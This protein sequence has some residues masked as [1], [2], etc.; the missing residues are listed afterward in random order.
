MWHIWL[1]SGNHWIE[2]TQA[3]IEESDARNVAVQLKRL[4]AL[5]QVFM[6]FDSDECEEVTYDSR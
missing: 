6:Q 2:A 3:F 1:K 4:F 5:D